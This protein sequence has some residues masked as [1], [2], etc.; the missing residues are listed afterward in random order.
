MTK[1]QRQ[2]IFDKFDGRC[3]YSGVPLGD[4]WQVDHINPKYMFIDY[5]HEDN[6]FFYKK[7]NEISNL[8]PT[9]KI[10]NH[11]KRAS[12]LEYFRTYMKD[13]HIRLGRLPKNPKVEKSKNRIV[14]MNKVADAFGIRPDRPFSGL[15]YFESLK[16]KS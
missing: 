16:Q 4:D 8:F 15:F 1:K 14:Y 7:A 11:Y 5:T 3:A 12:D 9:L 10:V 13:F 6:I 2:A